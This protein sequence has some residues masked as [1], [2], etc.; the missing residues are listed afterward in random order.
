MEDK[1]F[2]A[3]EESIRTDAAFSS[4]HRA[5][6]KADKDA[7]SAQSK[8]K[9]AARL[10]IVSTAV[11]AVLGGLLLYGLDTPT[12][13]LADS[14]LLKQIVANPKVR[15]V[16]V[17]MQ[18]I[19][20][21]VAGFFG[22]V[23]SN[24]RH[25]K[26]WLSNRTKAEDG[27]IRRA[28]AALVIGHA[29]GTGSFANAGEFYLADLIDGQLHYLS[30]ATDTSQ[31]NAKLLIVIGA[32]IAAVGALGAGLA[33][34][35]ASGL[36]LFG[37][38]VGVISPAF[39]SAL[40]TWESATADRQRATLHA[41]TWERLNALDGD[42]VSFETAIQS[43]DLEAALIWAKKVSGVLRADLKSFEALISNDPI[44]GDDDED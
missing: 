30:E 43:H 32:I 37:A 28:E 26:S 8:Y 12:E 42:R 11:A 36:L 16:L 3:L 25:D 19:S 18:A 15:V 44:I 34:V 39:V 7:V 41:A 33:G 13:G 4:V 1:V 5:A 14:P 29:K 17:V 27:R 2:Q 9:T 21:A 20:L 38:F 35:D 23:Q 10:F 24:S 22:Y 31:K 6:V 40:R